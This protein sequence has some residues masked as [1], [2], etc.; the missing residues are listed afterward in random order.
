MLVCCLGGPCACKAIDPPARGP[1]LV[2]EIPNSTATFPHPSSY[3]RA[4][5]LWND[6]MMS[7][8]AAAAVAGVAARRGDACAAFRRSKSARSLPIVAAPI[9]RLYDTAEGA[10]LLRRCHE[11]LEQQGFVA[12]RGFLS[13][14]AAGALLDEARALERDGN[15]SEG[16]FSTEEHGIFLTADDAVASCQVAGAAAQHPR[17]IQQKSSKHL[18]AADEVAENSLLRALYEWPPL[19][20]F[21]RA[22]LDRPNLH[23]SADPMGRFYL[24]FFRPGDQ[25]G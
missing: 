20:E 10:A 21:V 17:R 8:G 5:T 19:L 11:Q 22:A 1:G 2:V 23:L 9:E 15:G 14:D 3:L 12:I 16:F 18:F 25:L 4:S 7:R 13:E 6:M 24:N